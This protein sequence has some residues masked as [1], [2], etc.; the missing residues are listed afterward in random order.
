MKILVINKKL[1]SQILLNYPQEYLVKKVL[2]PTI[3]Y[4][5]DKLDDQCLRGKSFDVVYLTP[6]SFNENY[7][8][9]VSLYIDNPRMAIIESK[10]ILI[11]VAHENC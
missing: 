9:L 4:I 7:R 10:L 8:F 3:K 5:Y 6:N 1:L 11:F 2:I